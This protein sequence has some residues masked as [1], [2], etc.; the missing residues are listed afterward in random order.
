MAEEHERE[1]VI[2]TIDYLLNVDVKEPEERKRLQDLRE[3][4][5]GHES[6]HGPGRPA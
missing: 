6:E 2:E 3:R 4:V 5:V 1:N